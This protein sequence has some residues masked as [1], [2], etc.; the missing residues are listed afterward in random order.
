MQKRCINKDT[1]CSTAQGR[2]KL[3]Q[4]EREKIREGGTR[5]GNGRT[6]GYSTHL[7]RSS[8][9]NGFSSKHRG[10]K[11]K[12]KENKG[13]R[14]QADPNTRYNHPGLRRTQDGEKGRKAR[15]YETIGSYN[16][17]HGGRGPSDTRRW[18]VCVHVR[19][20]DV[21]SRGR[22]RGNDAR[23]CNGRVFRQERIKGKEE[24]ER[25]H[26]INPRGSWGQERNTSREP[27]TRVPCA[28][29]V[30]KG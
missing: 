9:F 13:E 14:T 25:V 24:R 26:L 23:L 6:K 4:I 29:V 11:Q 8:F 19:C 10:G 27:Q 20:N 3:S 5:K 12:R 16:E 15:G 30:T 2:D 7:Y 18:V 17:G 1:T 21:W 28:G 22:K